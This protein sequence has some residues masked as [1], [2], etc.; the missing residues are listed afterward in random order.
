[1]GNASVRLPVPAAWK[2]DAPR[3]G[4][5]LLARPRL[6]AKIEQAL[7]KQRKIGDVFL[8]S[9]PAGYG[10]TTLL[11]QWAQRAS[12]PIA[13]YHVDASDED[14]SVFFTGVV[15]ALR[16]QLPRSHWEVSALIRSVPPGSLSPLDT[17]R[18]LT[19]LLED[20]QANIR[21][22]L[23][24]VLMGAAELSVQG[25][26]HAILDSLL[27]RPPDA[28][29]LVLE[30][31]EVPAMRFSPLFTRGRLEGI[32][33]D[34]LS[35]DD[36]ELADL[37][38]LIGADDAPAYRELV[39]EVC[40]GWV[41]GVM[42]ATGTLTP[43]FLAMCSS[44]GMP[45]DGLNR[46]AVFDYFATEVIDALKEDKLRDFACDVSVFTRMTPTLCD[47]V[48]G[49]PNA[50]QYLATL[51]QRTGFLTS[52]GVRPDEP[53]YQFQ[54]LLR[55]ALLNRLERSPGGAARRRELHLH[56][57]EELEDAGELEEAVQQY[58]QAGAHERILQL[59]EAQRGSLL[60][61][62]HGATLARWLDALPCQI[63]DQRPDLQILLAELNRQAGHF[64]EAHELADRACVLTRSR[65][66]ENAA[67]LARAL[68]IR[69]SVRYTLGHYHDAQR[70]CEEAQRL[71]SDD[72][73][74]TH[75]LLHFTLAACLAMLATPEEADACLAAV[76][77]RCARQHDHWALARLNYYRSKA[78]LASGDFSRAE[79]EASTALLHAGEAGD[80]V[81]AIT[82]RLNLGAIRHFLGK[83]HLAHEDLEAARTQSEI[84]GYIAGEVYAISNLGDLELYAGRHADAIRLYEESLTALARF[85]DKHLHS[86]TVAALSYVFTLEGQ[87][88][89]ALELVA[90][91]LADN[92]DQRQSTDWILLTTSMGIANYR[93]GNL[94]RATES[95]SAACS[96]ARE[97]GALVESVR[98]HLYLAAVYS[99]EQRTEAVRAQLCAA[100]DA[101]AAAKGTGAMLL[102]VRHL[103][104]IWP[105][106]DQIA[107]PQ[108]GLARGHVATQDHAVSGDP[109]A[110][111]AVV[112]ATPVRPAP[113]IRV[114][115]LGNP[116]VC[117]GD[118]PV[119][120][121]RRRRT[122][123]LLYFMLEQRKPIHKDI[124]L[125]AL[126]M[127]VDP[128]AADDAFRKTRSHL[129]E[130]LGRPCLE[131]FDGRWQLTL[132]CWV[133]V[134][135]FEGLLDEGKQL[136][137]A[138]QISDAART[139]H[140]ALAHW[141]GPFLE[142]CYNNWAILRRD[143]LQTRYMN[144]IERLIGLELR[145]GH[146]EQ[147]AQLSAHLLKLQPDHELAHRCLMT[148]LARRGEYAAAL[149]QFERCVESLQEVGDTPG[150]RTL[151][152]YHTIR[153]KMQAAVSALDTLRS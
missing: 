43:N 122:R 129:K 137:D 26:T 105:H 6:L 98:A 123:D 89:R 50:R 35:L 44:Y 42:L 110:S 24:L 54:P 41:T 78:H 38:T 153:T 22:P 9:A 5:R 12:I 145:L 142:D 133:D 73:D 74:E 101:V 69:A 151:A 132:E 152:L 120:H 48:L 37:L 143:T 30:F 14:P 60:R 15:R 116:R 11:A 7:G 32:G 66:G 92:R 94:D 39:R 58:L 23:A 1:M 128:D 62:C 102:E 115:A 96:C 76:E 27:T 57:G 150:P 68:Q 95:L 87:P 45:A 106:L 33:V 36:V 135:E 70:D 72:D 10:K 61:A 118:A 49:Q 86:Y 21:K 2:Y 47:K 126:W 20:L 139:L 90:P 121:W 131:Q 91:L 67:L 8:V 25:A 117:I 141:E 124:I 125:N 34:D 147:A 127:G 16:A 149:N 107:H 52:F 97:H 136:A 28:L 103:P 59:I 4:S 83:S 55:Q 65:E 77:D 46:A 51:E 108:I 82:S 88:A 81:T 29:R 13:W 140:R 64:A 119:A 19:V 99:T 109:L 113:A 84:A 18:A 79:Q 146:D 100:L 63:R 144:C 134:R 3:L 138:G 111:S 85:N 17:E 104:E 148:Y 112:D 56:A 130:I 93:L 80:E 71:A 53:T 31:R 75:I 40:S 114:Y